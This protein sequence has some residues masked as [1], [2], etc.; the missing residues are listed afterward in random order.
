MSPPDLRYTEEHEWARVESGGVAVI[1]ITEFAAESLGDVVFIDLPPVDTELTGAKKMGEIES[2][3]AVS[4][5]YSPISG[6]VIERNE[7]AM[8]N[9]EM[10]NESPYGSGWLIRLAIS[11]PSAMD[12]LMTADQY[13]AF[14]ASQEQ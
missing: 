12:K 2:V 10:V 9:P 7:Q 11:D 14:L 4:D 1:G 5:I 8:E 6:R 3:K 13:E